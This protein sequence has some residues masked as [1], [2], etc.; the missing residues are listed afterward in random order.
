MEAITWRCRVR[1]SATEN[2]HLKR[3][4]RVQLA[5]S[6][7]PIRRY[8]ATDN[9]SRPVML[10]TVKDQQNLLYQRHLTQEIRSLEN[11]IS[12]KMNR[13]GLIIGLRPISQLELAWQNLI[14][15]WI[16]GNYHQNC[17]SVITRMGTSFLSA[18]ECVG[19]IT[20]F[21]ENQHCQ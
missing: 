21:A 20:E 11:S 10:L 4:L 6:S 16:E 9:H 18:F 19:E 12:Y 14:S 7:L 3:C 15:I 17:V 13:R 2:D 1:H 5:S 8:S